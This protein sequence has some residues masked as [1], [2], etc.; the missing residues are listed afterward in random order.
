MFNKTREARNKLLKRQ[1]YLNQKKTI[2]GVQEISSFRSCNYT[3]RLSKFCRNNPNQCKVIHVVFR[4][5]IKSSRNHAISELSLDFS[6]SSS[7]VVK[8]YTYFNNSFFLKKIKLY[9]KIFLYLHH[10]PQ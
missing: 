2:N 3:Q 8:I 1:Y 9:R 4:H 10:E 7:K 5:S 6:G